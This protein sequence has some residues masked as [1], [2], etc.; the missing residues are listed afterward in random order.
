V[1]SAMTLSQN[2][3]V[4]LPSQVTITG[5]TCSTSACKSPAAVYA[6]SGFDGSTGGWTYTAGIQ[7]VTLPVVESANNSSYTNN[8][9]FSYTLAAVPRNWLAMIGG[10]PVNPPSFLPPLFLLGGTGPDI[11]AVGNCS[12]QV[13][14]QLVL[15]ATSNPISFTGSNTVTG[16]YSV[17]TAAPSVSGVTAGTPTATSQ[18]QLPDPYA[19]LPAPDTSGL[20][21]FSTWNAS[22][23]QPGIYTNSVDINSNVPLPSGVY[24]FNKGFTNSGSVDGRAGVL[25]Y[26]TGGVINSTGHQAS[27]N[28]QP[29][30]Y[31]PNVAPNLTIWQVASDTNTIT[32]Q[33][34]AA[35]STIGGTIYAPS[36]QISQGGT[37]SITA[38]SILSKTLACN[39]TPTYLIGAS[40]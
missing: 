11:S 9:S 35:T 19:N 29:L 6:A 20:P 32:I 4:G 22:N 18:P 2:V 16:T 38:G 34:N 14:G 8:G 13:T 37:T 21:T 25:F 10:N 39:G 12:I 30:A 26:V 28:L 7:S 23:P 5:S 31:P 3:Q 15:N 36:A 24:Q 27:L 40:G 1:T 33:G 17:Y